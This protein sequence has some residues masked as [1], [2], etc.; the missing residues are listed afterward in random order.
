MSVGCQHNH[1]Q[2]SFMLQSSYSCHKVGKSL[3]ELDPLWRVLGRGSQEVGGARTLMMSEWVL[4]W[5]SL[6]NGHSVPANEKDINI[7]ILHVGSASLHKGMIHTTSS[8]HHHSWHHALSYVL[9]CSVAIL[10]NMQDPYLA[11]VIN[12]PYMYMYMQIYPLA[13][14][15]ELCQFVVHNL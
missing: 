8:K 15:Y 13:V 14:C 4:T 9:C 7:I 5:C 11:P 10:Y 1:T 3:V 2:T 12:V 6:Q